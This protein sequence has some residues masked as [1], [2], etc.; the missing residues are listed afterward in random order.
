MPGDKI[1]LI[2]G[3]PLVYKLLEEYADQQEND[4]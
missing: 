3:Y 1:V 4:Q 2:C